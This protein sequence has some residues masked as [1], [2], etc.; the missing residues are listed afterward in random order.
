M[1]RGYF[2]RPYPNES[3]PKNISQVI[4]AARDRQLPEKSVL[5]EPYPDGVMGIR[6]LTRNTALRLHGKNFRQRRTVVS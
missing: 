4:V 1:G 6:T 5:D 3:A 2:F